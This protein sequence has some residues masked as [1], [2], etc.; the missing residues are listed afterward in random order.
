MDQPSRFPMRRPR[1]SHL[2][3]A[4]AVLAMCALILGIL[5]HGAPAAFGDVAIS[6][7]AQEPRALGWLLRPLMIAASAPGNVPLV[8]VIEVTALGWAAARGARADFALIILAA[9][10]D[11]LVVGI[12]IVVARPRPTDDLVAVYQRITSASF[13]SGHVV[14]YVVF[15]GA[16]AYLVWRVRASAVPGW[17]WLRLAI[18][19]ASA[20]LIVLIGPSRIYLGVHWPTDVLG[21]YLIGIVSLAPLIFA[22]RRL[23]RQRANSVVEG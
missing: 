3:A 1:R 13:P 5:V 9:L 11:L 17:P 22:H 23:A 8:L 6:Q 10:V 4:W 15:F 12:K 21:G 16:L 2:V 14:H 7:E 20:A 18:V 19:V